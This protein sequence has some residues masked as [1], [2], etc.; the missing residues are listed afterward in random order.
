MNLLFSQRPAFIEAVAC[1]IL[2]ARDSIM[3][4]AC[5]AVV[6]VLPPGVFMTTMPRLL[7]AGMSMLSTP[8]PARPMAES[9]AAASMISAV[10]LVAERTIRAS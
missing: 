7:A 4:M 10:T 3:A 8:A 6:T 5:S 9:F 2:R 1:G